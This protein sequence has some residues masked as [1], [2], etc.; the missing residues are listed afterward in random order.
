M[1]ETQTIRQIAERIRAATP[2]GTR[3]IVFGSVARGTARPNSDLD[4]LVVEPEQTNHYQ[5]AGRLYRLMRGIKTPVDILV[6]DS[7]TFEAWKDTSCT[8]FNEACREGVVL[9]E[10]A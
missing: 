1:I 7:A 4:L 9:G 8:V 6:T 5:E 10:P 3:I 2:R